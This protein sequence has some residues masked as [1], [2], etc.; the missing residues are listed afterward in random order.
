M[1]VAKPRDAT[2]LTPLGLYPA[3]ITGVSAF[4]E[5]RYAARGWAVALGLKLYHSWTARFRA[6]LGQRQTT[7]VTRF[8][9]YV[10]L[11]DATRY[12]SRLLG[13]GTLR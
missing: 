11:I 13:Y 9:N 2:T 12:A 10:G 6:I 4:H 8:R 3:T 7:A 1:K 5:S